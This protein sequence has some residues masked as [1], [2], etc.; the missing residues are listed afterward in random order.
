MSRD[1]SYQSEITTVATWLIHNSK[2]I[3]SNLLKTSLIS[4]CKAFRKIKYCLFQSKLCAKLRTAKQINKDQYR[5]QAE[6]HLKI[7][8]NK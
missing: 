8:K 7:N 5:F 4:I 1:V 3:D 2:K 6:Q